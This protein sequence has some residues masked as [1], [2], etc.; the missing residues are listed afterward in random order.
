[1]ARSCTPQR[2]SPPDAEPAWFADGTSWMNG[3]DG[4]N[5][6]LKNV[7]AVPLTLRPSFV[8]TGSWDCGARP[9]AFQSNAIASS[10]A[11][12]RTIATASSK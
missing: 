1:M 12:K 11:R 8:P 5:G 6:Y 3:G 2:I 9:R 7:I 4:P 10:P